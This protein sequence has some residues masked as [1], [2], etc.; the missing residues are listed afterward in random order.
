LLAQ[1]NADTLLSAILYTSDSSD[2]LGTLINGKWIVKDQ[3]HILSEKIA[4]NFIAA[5][6]KLN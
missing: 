6:K 1:A 5:I 3:V 2:I 4:A